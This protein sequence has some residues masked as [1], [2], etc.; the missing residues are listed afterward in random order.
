[1]TKA[2]LIDIISTAPS[3]ARAELLLTLELKSR[4][5]AACRERLEGSL[6]VV[7]TTTSETTTNAPILNRKYRP[8]FYLRPFE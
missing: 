8:Q 2:E 3:G 5:P 4:Q 7:E 1:M 6:Q